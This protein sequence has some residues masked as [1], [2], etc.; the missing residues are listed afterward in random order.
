MQ[1]RSHQVEILIMK[2]MYEPVAIEVNQKK[3]KRNP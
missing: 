1:Q 2:T 3:K